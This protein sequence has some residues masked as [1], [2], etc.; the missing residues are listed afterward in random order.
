MKH[1]LAAKIHCSARIRERLRRPAIKRDIDKMRLALLKNNSDCFI[2][3]EYSDVI[4]GLVRY[5]N[6]WTIA[7]LDKCTGIIKTVGV[8]L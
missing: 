6:I 4:K 1:K 5:Q 7:V 8:S 3:R 2:R